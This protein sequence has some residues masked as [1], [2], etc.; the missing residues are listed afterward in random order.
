MRKFCLK[1]NCT[2]R[3]ADLSL[4]LAVSLYP[5]FAY[6]RRSLG[7]SK[8]SWLASTVLDAGLKF[9]KKTI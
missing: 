6:I 7:D 4:P 2:L 5:R 9:W 3:A 8:D 1:C